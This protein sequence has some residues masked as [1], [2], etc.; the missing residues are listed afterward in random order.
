[1]RL[2]NMVEEH[3]NEREEW[4][5]AMVDSNHSKK[6]YLT[7]ADQ[8]EIEEGIEK[9]EL[10]CFENHRSHKLRSARPLS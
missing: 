9:K 3:V 7:P 6:K 5:W 8:A 1:M 4:W 10:V 2:F